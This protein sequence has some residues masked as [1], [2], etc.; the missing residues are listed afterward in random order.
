MV[1]PVQKCNDVPTFLKELCLMLISE[2][3]KEGTLSI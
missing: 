3:G 1:L 2:M